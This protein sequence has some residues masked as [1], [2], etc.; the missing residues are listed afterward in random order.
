MR[1]WTWLISAV[2]VASM[3]IP[4][5]A[6]DPSSFVGTMEVE[7]QPMQSAGGKKGCTLV[8]RVVGQ[9]YAHRKGNLISLAGNLGYQT[10]EKR[11]NVALSL[12]RGDR[13]P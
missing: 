11:A 1:K 9:D 7:F 6:L 10:D 8:Y 3:A 4:L 2:I 5:Q 13:Q 12:D